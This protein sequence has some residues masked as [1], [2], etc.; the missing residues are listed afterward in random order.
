M[1]NALD[2]EGGRIA[3]HSTRH[4]PTSLRAPPRDLPG[5]YEIRFPQES[6]V[7]YLDLGKVEP[8]EEEPKP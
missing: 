7:A 2:T 3:F 4:D 6:V 8:T 1:C 5:V